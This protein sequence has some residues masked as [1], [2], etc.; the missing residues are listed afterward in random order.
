MISV[1]SRLG[2]GSDIE[3]VIVDLWPS[4]TVV[5]PDLGLVDDPGDL[6]GWVRS[7]PWLDVDRVVYGLAWLA[8][9]EGGR[10]RD[11]A[12][13]LAWLLL[14]RASLLAGELM[15][16]SREINHVVAAELWVLVR[17]F[18]LHRRKV[19]ANLSWDLR[20][21]VLLACGAPASVQRRD[22]V[23]FAT[24]SALDFDLSTIAVDSAPS[25]FDELV[26]VLDWAC[27]HDW[28]SVEDRQL[29]LLLVDASQGVEIRKTAG[30][31]LLTQ[32]ATGEVA[33]LLGISARTVRRRASSSISALRDAVASCGLVA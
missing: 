15:S 20:S 33:N 7:G 31:G 32:Q 23:W 21:R 6:R 27:A 11:A 4:W 29:L 26:E 16:L 17:S 5:V 3:R 9:M 1:E 22:P 8:S 18:P 24:V 19:L 28:L 25:A 14:P 12:R 13:V 2:L 10:D 30:A